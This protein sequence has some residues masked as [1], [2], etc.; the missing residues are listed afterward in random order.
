MLREEALPQ[1][2]ENERLSARSYAVGQ[3]GL[4]EYLLI[5]REL[6]ETRALYLDRLL[7]AALAWIR[8]QASTGGL[9]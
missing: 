9:S 7:D 8:L 3:I 6:R 1:L 2:E 4:A 5:R